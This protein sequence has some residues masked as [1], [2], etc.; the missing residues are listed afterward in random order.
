M[1]SHLH[2]I[3]ATDGTGT[4]CQDRALAAL[5]ICDR[6]RAVIGS[7]LLRGCRDL[8]TGRRI[9]WAKPWG[10][11]I[12]L[13][14]RDGNFYDPSTANLSY[15]ARA[16]EMELPKPWQQLIA[17]V[18]VSQREQARLVQQITGGHPTA[19]TLPDA[20]YLPGVVYAS[21]VEEL[22]TS[23]AY[24]TAWGRL[25]SESFKA[26]GWDA[27]QL[28]TSLARVDEL[29]AGPLELKAFKVS[30]HRSSSARRAAQGFAQGVR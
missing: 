30:R 26:G 13:M 14:E 27:H 16:Q 19:D 12:W 2:I 15:W 7:L 3:T 21:D 23:P 9:P 4:N 25:A 28:E 1:T 20:I 6:A 5:A 10:H 8:R 11:H 29:M 17:G 18:I 22:P 24:V